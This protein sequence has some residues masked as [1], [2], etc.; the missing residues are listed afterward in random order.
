MYNLSIT[1]T[2]KP[3]HIAFANSLSFLDGAAALDKLWFSSQPFLLRY[4]A[5]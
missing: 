2:C 1:Q 3:G 4:E 5:R